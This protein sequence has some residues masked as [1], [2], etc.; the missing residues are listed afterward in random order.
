MQTD[1]QSHDV[2]IALELLLNT[3]I[4]ERGRIFSF[5]EK[6]MSK[7]DKDTA[8]AVLDFADKLEGFEAKVQSLTKEWQVLESQKLKASPSVQKIVDAGGKLFGLKTR[9][10]Q[11]GIK[12]EFQHPKAPKSNIV[13]TFPA[14]GKEF[15]TEKAGKTFAQ[16]I[17]YIGAERVQQL[18]LICCGEP[19]VSSTPSK[20][21]PSN[22][23]KISK[24]FFVLTQ[25]STKRKIDYLNTIAK[26]LKLKTR[27]KIF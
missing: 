5:G 17:D 26:L 20:K 25:S 15:K 16:V 12:R 7:Q 22:C 21:Y 1:D 9:K 19:L 27:I 8:K 23:H 11:S 3:L 4:E 2:S 14:E 13:V 10:A 18:K 6:A 24:G